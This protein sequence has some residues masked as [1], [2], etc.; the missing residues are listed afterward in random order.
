MYHGCKTRSKYKGDDDVIDN[1]IKS[2]SRSTFW[3]AITLLIFKL[4][5]RTNAQK[6]GNWIRYL[7]I[8]LISKSSQ[9]LQLSS[10][11]YEL[12]SFWKFWQVRNLRLLFHFTGTGVI[13][14]LPLAN[15]A[16]LTK[17]Q[18]IPRIMHIVCILL[19][20][21]VVV[22]AYLTV[23]GAIHDDVIKWKHF[24]CYSPFVQGI[25]WSLVNSPLK[26]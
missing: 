20:F 18:N 24:L 9:S 26:G 19:C 8:I 17:K 5:R 14:W 21:A 11:C 12:S 16:T 1:I 22:L 3:T 6:E 15:I 23:T 2:K 7:D 13:I 25:H 4:E 10:L